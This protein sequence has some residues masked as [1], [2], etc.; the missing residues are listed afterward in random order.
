MPPVTQ[1]LDSLPYPY[2]FVYATESIISPSHPVETVTVTEEE[3]VTI[4]LT[5]KPTTVTEF[6]TVMPSHTPLVSPSPTGP[7]DDDRPSWKAPTPLE[8]FDSFNVLK[9]ASGK[10]NMKIVSGI[11]P[12]ASARPERTSSNKKSAT[13]KPYVPWDNSSSVLQIFYPEGTVDPA[14]DPVGG[15]DFYAA[16]IDLG[17]ARNVSFTFSVFFPADFDWVLAGKLPGLYGGHDGC[18]GGNA[19]LDCFSTRLM[20]REDGAGELYLVSYLSPYGNRD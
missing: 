20:W 10:D 5:Q 19:A 8:N 1:T 9:F 14:Q 13:T 2:T 16:P 15:A 12:K 3:P 11:P 17:D 6:I 18:S 4:T 7:T